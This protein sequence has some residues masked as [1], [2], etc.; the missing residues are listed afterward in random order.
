MTYKEIVQNQLNQ[1][2][3]KEPITTKYLGN[4]IGILYYTNN[5]ISEKIM[6]YCLDRLIESEK[7]ITAVS[8]TELHYINS[9][10][11]NIVYESTL[12]PIT[13]SIYR[14]ILLGLK[15]MKEDYIYFAEHDVLYPKDYFN[16]IHVDGR[17]IAYNNNIKRLNIEGFYNFEEFPPHKVT[18]LSQLSGWRTDLIE[19]FTNRLANNNKG[20][21][22][23]WVE[24]NELNVVQYTNP[25]PTV[26]LRLENNHTGNRKPR[27]GQYI[28][29]CEYWG[30]ATSLLNELITTETYENKQFPRTLI[31]TEL[32]GNFDHQFKPL[33]PQYINKNCDYVLITNRTDLD[34][35]DFEPYKIIID[36]A[37]YIDMTPRQKSRLYKFCPNLLENLLD[38]T[39]YEYTI[40]HDTNI[41]IT[42]PHKLIGENKDA[43]WYGYRHKARRCLYAEM[44]YIS[45]LNII[46]PEMQLKARQLSI[47]LIND[48]IPNLLGL[49]ELGIITRKN[50]E[51]M[52]EFGMEWW[53]QYIESGVDNDQII[54]PSLF[55]NS[56]IKFCPLKGN[57][58]QN[59]GSIFTTR[60]HDK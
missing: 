17:N 43:E 50:T 18:M 3:P 58:Y 25:S 27:N 33:A 51:R 34:Q 36:Q 54:L 37:Q 13:S 14:Q 9:N 2:K 45:R 12:L 20:N 47:K 57:V 10:L 32:F 16:K 7:H 11:I 28:Q 49:L 24:P 39:K 31:F 1:Q 29:S 30:G 8:Q 59:E 4:T 42:N 6:N 38:M 53:K 44:E 15:N 22:Y 41:Q 19:I 48:K 56:N 5:N 23:D 55:F 26:D 40:Y 60:R 46:S 21:W 52:R 35:K